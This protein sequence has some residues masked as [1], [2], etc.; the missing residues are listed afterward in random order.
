MIL[1]SMP[2]AP[3]HKYSNFRPRKN[4]IRLAGLSI[5]VEN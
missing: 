4:D 1:A 5:G 3:V 2:E